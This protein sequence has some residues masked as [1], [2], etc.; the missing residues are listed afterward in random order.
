M[1]NK[2]NSRGFT[3]VELLIV[4]VVIAILAAISVVAYNGVQNRAK[5]TVGK[6]LAS[7]M[8]K[9]LEAYNAVN[10]SYP[11]T[12]TQIQATAESKIDNL[13]AVGVASTT[14]IVTDTTDTIMSTTALTSGTALSGSTVRINGTATGGNVYYWDYSLSTPAEA[15]VHYG[16]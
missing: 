1:T 15:S 4:I 16:A 11:T 8:V 13:T 2:R 5:A 7:Q 10:G 14:P 12:K 9:K 3:L 6:E